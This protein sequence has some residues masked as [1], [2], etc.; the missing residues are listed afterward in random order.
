MD[1]KEKF[2]TYYKYDGGFWFRIFGFGVS[3]QNRVKHPA[4]FSERN[5][6]KKTMRF[7]NW[8]IKYLSRENNH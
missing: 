2:L 8:A 7:G 4:L 5:G 6:F 1:V 3:I